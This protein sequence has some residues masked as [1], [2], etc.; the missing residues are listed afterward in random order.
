M[1]RR[2][3]NKIFR[4]VIPALFVF[5][6]L[7]TGFSASAKPALVGIV[8]FQINGPEELSYLKQG[9]LD[10]LTSRLS[11]KDEVEVVALKP[12]EGLM[13]ESTAREMGLKTGTDWILFGSLTVLG[14]G[15]SIDTKMVDV[16]EKKPTH[17]SF[18]QSGNMNDLISQINLLAE[19]IN[20][21]VFGRGAVA[22]KAPGKPD[23]GK[24]ADDIRAHPEKLL[25]GGFQESGSDFQPISLRPGLTGTFWRSAR[26]KQ[27]ITGLAL[28]DVNDDGQI[29]TVV[30]TPDSVR[31]YS[32]RDKRFFEAHKID[33]TRFAYNIG[34]DVADINGNGY[35]EIFVTSLNPQKNALASFVLEYNGQKFVPIVE[36]SPWFYRVISTSG[37]NRVLL[38]QRTKLRNPFSGDISEM[39]WKGGEYLPENTLLASKLYNLM[40]FA[41]GDVQNSGSGLFVVFSRSDRLRVMAPSGKVDWEGDEKY[42]GSSLFYNTGREEPGVDTMQFLPTRLL[43]WDIDGN[44]KQ[45]VITIRNHDALGGVLERIR[46]YTKGQLVSL[47]WD[48]IGLAPSWET[49]NVSGFIRDFG[50]GDFDNDGVEELVAAVV[51]KEGAIIGTDPT[52]AIIAYELKERKE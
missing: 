23:Q 7:S 39:K 43:V 2:A 52:S 50:I 21:N 38:G 31:I 9:I 12:G 41:R 18:A 10:M 6:S 19:D 16:S 48:G 26:Y 11:W 4:P 8:P 35:D 51:I 13:D 5:I 24:P 3:S 34:V 25:K 45:E 30:V 33:R 42:G 49:R 44:G 22:R 17:A 32:Y 47:V 40:G 29:E 36:K 27:L 37:E 1:I 20:Q 46:K 28:G 14:T 15:A